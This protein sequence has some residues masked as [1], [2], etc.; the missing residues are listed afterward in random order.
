MKKILFVLSLIPVTAAHAFVKVAEVFTSNMV[1]QQEK[2]IRVW[3]TADA[4][5]QVKVV[6]GK[7]KTMTTADADGRWMAELNPMKA[8]AKPQT[9]TIS[10]KKNKVVLKNLLVGEVWLA[11]GQS[12]MEYSMNAHPKYVRPKKGDPEYLKHEWVKAKNP[13][14]RLLYIEKNV[15]CDTLPT[16]GW[17]MVTQESLTPFS[18]AAWFFAEMLQDS[19]Q[20]PVGIITSAWGGTYIED[21]MDGESPFGPL[22]SQKNVHG[23][24]YDKMIR[25]MAPLSLRGFL[26]YQGEANLL[27]GDTNI[28]TQKQQHLVNQ[29]RKA[30]RDDS[31][32]FYY[33]QISPYIYS[34]RRELVAKTWLDLPRFWDAQTRCMDVISNSGMVVTTDIPENLNDIHPPYKWVVGRRLARWALHDVYGYKQLECSGPRLRS[35]EQKDNKV[36]LTFDHCE[37]GLTTFDGKEPSWFQ[38]YDARRCK[39]VGCIAEINNNQVIITIGNNQRPQIRFGY[40]E[41]AQPN[42]CNKAGLPAIPFDIKL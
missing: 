15:K 1:L 7:Q 36:V 12:N 19:L 35:A 32:P 8:T 39:F 41:V 24:R 22:P 5:E 21:W 38:I 37:D 28:Y 16:H 6:L 40:D 26:W 4:G 2:N 3:G 29:W 23:Q 9:M 31:L 34:T 14:I 18:A 25:P 27:D 10:S 17:Q 11:S 42:L 33:V 30:F 13:H 20:V